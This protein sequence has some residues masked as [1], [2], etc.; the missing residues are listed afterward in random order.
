[1]FVF[2]HVCMYL[3]YVRTLCTYVY[4]RSVSS[5][6]VCAYA[7]CTIPQW[8]LDW[9]TDIRASGLGL[10]LGAT[11]RSLAEDSLARVDPQMIL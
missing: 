4:I 6:T 3:M 1:M 5:I 10:G 7:Y 9:L 11:T 8:L 2:M